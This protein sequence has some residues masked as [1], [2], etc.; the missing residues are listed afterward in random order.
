MSSRLNTLIRLA[1]Q[2][3]DVRQELLTL[4]TAE[5]QRTA[6]L[7]KMLDVEAERAEN[8]VDADFEM[9]VTHRYQGWSARCS[10][11][12]HRF[13]AKGHNFENLIDEI[14]AQLEVVQ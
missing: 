7:S 9:E 12:R 5:L 11:G 3:P 6:S 10:L 1:H 8:V 14:V 13:Q 2:N 4:V